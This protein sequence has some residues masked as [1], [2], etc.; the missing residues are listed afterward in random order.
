MTALKLTEVIEVIRHTLVV[1]ASCAL[2]ACS[3]SDSPTP[4]APAAASSPAT[5]APQQNSAATNA[6]AAQSNEPAAA[7]PQP[8]RMSQAE[9]QAAVG[10][11]QFQEG[12]HYERL[13]PQQPTVETDGDLVEVVEVFQ[14]NCPACF[15]FEPYLEQW[16]AE[17]PDYINFVRLPAPWSA[18]SELHARAYYT[19]Q[20]LG[21]T[22]E[23]HS[24]IFREFHVNRNMLASEDALADFFADYGVDEETFA[25]TFNSFAV[26][27]KMQRGK[28]LV[29]RYRVSGTP[30]IVV[31]G[32]YLTGGQMAQSYENWFAILEELAAVEWAEKGQ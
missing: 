5:A 8:Q 29:Q 17:K 27:T 26:H 14:Y 20:A 28:D 6:R 30:G 1:F 13:T 31:A 32:K 25:A 18:Q 21:I 2:F 19:A 23:T 11:R 24:A 12:S 22:D 15:S 3:G 9:R 4:Q 7:A 16:L 10:E